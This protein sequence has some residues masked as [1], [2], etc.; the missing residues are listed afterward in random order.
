[1]KQIPFFSL[2]RQ[3]ELYQSKLQ[4]ALDSVLKSQQF[5]GGSIVEN[6]EK[7]LASYV[8]AS[9]AIAC[10][11]GTDALWLA[12]E[13]LNVNP[14]TI[15]LTTP[16]SF[17]ASS[18]EIVAHGG[19]PVFIDIDRK[20]YNI[21]PVKLN[22]WLESE[23]I[24]QGSITIHKQTGLQVAGIVTVDLFGQCADYHQIK[25]IASTWNLWIVEDACQ[26]IGAE[27]DHKKAGTLGD[28][29]AFSFY[30]TKN[31]GAF[32]DGGALTTNNSFYAEKLTQLRNHG[33]ISH[34]DYKAIGI[35]SRLD[36]MQASLLSA[37]LDLIDELNNKRRAIAKIYDEELAHLSWLELPQQTTGHHVYHQYSV[38]I[39]G[40]GTDTLRNEFVAYL[41]QQG[42]QTRIFYPKML[43]EIDFLQT[44]TRLE[45]K[46]PVAQRTVNQIVSLPIWPELTNEEVLYVC[47]VIKNFMHIQTTTHHQKNVTV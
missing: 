35:N 3:W 9:H 31:L 33:R 8:N 44:D 42:V 10:N 15:V 37:K 23:T 32:G 34:Y 39:L 36:G 6:F 2:A 46:C 14:R 18:S 17:I 11:S 40:D 12:L 47:D 43:H 24:R 38:Q 22:F 13:V 1:M 45:T 19:H 28:I 30:P 26:A 21:D 20:S 25:S 5:I 7:K 4:P 29:T 27:F 16:F 41:E